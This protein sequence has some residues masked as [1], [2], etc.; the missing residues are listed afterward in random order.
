MVGTYAEPDGLH[1]PPDMSGG[2]CIFGV[3]NRVSE[4][5]IVQ[6]AGVGFSPVRQHALPT[7]KCE[8]SEVWW[9]GHVRRGRVRKLR[10]ADVQPTPLKFYT[11]APALSLH[12]CHMKN[13]HTST[14][15]FSQNVLGTCLCHHLLLPC[16]VELTLRFLQHSAVLIFHSAS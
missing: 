8:V 7:L 6:R 5:R 1:H 16:L 10:G 2:P 12:R 13:S 15:N 9:G 4:N 14:L 3:L 11:G